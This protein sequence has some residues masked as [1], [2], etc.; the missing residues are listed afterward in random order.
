MVLAND[1]AL[2]YLIHHFLCVLPSFL[3]GNQQEVGV[4][5]EEEMLE[6][7]ARVA[8][9]MVEVGEVRVV[10]GVG[11]LKEGGVEE[12]KLEAVVVREDE[13]AQKNG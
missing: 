2:S 7:E 9:E 4:E 5:G 12:E 11:F 13:V 6:V 8:I 3:A 1:V 10:V